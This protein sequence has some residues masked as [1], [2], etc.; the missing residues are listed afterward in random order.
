MDIMRNLDPSYIRY[1]DPLFIK[2]CRKALAYYD[3]YIPYSISYHKD[4]ALGGFC[5]IEWQKRQFDILAYGHGKW[6]DK[7]LLNV[8]LSYPFEKLKAWE[9]TMS[10]KNT[11]IRSL[12]LALRF[13]AKIS[14]QN[15]NSTNLKITRKDYEKFITS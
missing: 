4:K 14:G 3:K 9:I 2:E 13:G 8:F 12:R 11:N 1:N 5:L 7:T 10:I 15:V 6:I